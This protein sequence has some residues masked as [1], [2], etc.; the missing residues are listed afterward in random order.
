MNEDKCPTCFGVGKI[1]KI[2]NIGLDKNVHIE[3]CPTCM[4]SIEKDTSDFGW[5]N[6]FE[7]GKSLRNKAL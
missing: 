2:I 3:D 5:V 1:R 7:D 6:K 4:N